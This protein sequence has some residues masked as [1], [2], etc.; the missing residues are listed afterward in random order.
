MFKLNLSKLRGLYLTVCV[1]SL[2]I[3]YSS[4]KAETAETCIVINAPENVHS[5]D[6]FEVSVIKNIQE[7]ETIDS[8]IINMELSTQFYFKKNNLISSNFDVKVD[9]SKKNVTFTLNKNKILSLSPGSNELIRLKINVKKKASK[10]VNGLVSF[11][12]NNS[13]E[14]ISKTMLVNPKAEVSNMLIDGK[15]FEFDKNKKDYEITVPIDKEIIDIS[16]MRTEGNEKIPD[17][18]ISKKLNKNKP[19]TFKIEDYNLKVVKEKKDN[20]ESSKKKNK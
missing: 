12:L 2:F 5:G 18:T 9:K 14:K 13:N 10:N 8:I 15:D 6:E 7:N 3:C 4:S 16:I 20:S 11:S 1:P 17:E 19:K